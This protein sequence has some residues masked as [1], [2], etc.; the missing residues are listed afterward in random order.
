[1]R[2]RGKL[3]NADKLLRILQA[4]DKIRK[5]CIVRLCK[6]QIMFISKG[7]ES[8]GG[9]AV[10]EDT[11]QIWSGVPTSSLFSE[12]RLESLL[13]N[14]QIYIVIN[15]DHAIRALQ[16]HQSANSIVMSLTK[17]NNQ[18]YLTAD[19]RIDS[20]N[21]Q[22]ALSQ[23]IPVL[24]I[25]LQ[26]EIETI[27]EPVTNPRVQIMMPGLKE[28]KPIIDRMQKI[29]TELE[30]EANMNHTIIFRVT[31]SDGIINVSTY[32][33]NLEHPYALAQNGNDENQQTAFNGVEILP[34]RSTPDDQISVTSCIEI[35][36]FQRFLHSTVLQPTAVVL[37]M[38][39]NSYLVLNVN[40]AD[41]SY[42]TYYLNVLRK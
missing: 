33:K 37:G 19:I 38:V 16:S 24:N 30:I 42:M 2:F 1:M 26:S 22:I 39:P 35:K 29:G 36:R 20:Q 14:N 28:L 11:T 3:A 12:F 15:V 25:L 21:G 8:L 17:K 4:V 40:T 10:K 34:Q 41:S 9:V 23:D 5:E 13:T 7:D 18:V 32:F 31:D 6:T 27:S